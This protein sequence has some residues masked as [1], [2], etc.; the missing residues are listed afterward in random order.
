MCLDN[1]PIVEHLASLARITPAWCREAMRLVC[2][3]DVS[4]LVEAEVRRCLRSNQTRHRRNGSDC[5]RGERTEADVRAEVSARGH[6]LFASKFVRPCF[7]ESIS[8]TCWENLVKYAHADWRFGQSPFTDPE[9]MQW[10]ARKGLATP[11]NETERTWVQRQ[12]GARLGVDPTSINRWETGDTVPSGDKVLGAALVALT[13]EIADCE[14]GDRAGV[15]SNAMHRT[16]ALIRESR[17]SADRGRRADAIPDRDQIHA[18]RQFHL[19]SAS[20][21]F[22]DPAS[23]ATDRSELLTGLIQRLRECAPN[24]LRWDAASI[25][26]TIDDWAMPYALLRLGLV[27]GWPDGTE[28]EWSWEDIDEE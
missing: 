19:D 24:G 9:Y 23:S 7:L 25:R 20:S 6:H 15:I 26:S 22:L 3:A 5:A 27:A 17:F 1:S 14:L 13:D 11:S 8:L 12:I 10:A 28:D 18:V 21:L 4:G 16:L 2:V